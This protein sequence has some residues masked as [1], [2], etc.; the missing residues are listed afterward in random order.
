MPR[1]ASRTG[2][3]SAGGCRSYGFL[4]GS[5]THHLFLAVLSLTQPYSPVVFFGPF[6]LSR[7][8]GILKV[9]PWPGI[10]EPLSFGCQ[11]ERELRPSGTYW[12][13]RSESG[14]SFAQDISRLFPSSNWC[15]FG[16]LDFPVLSIFSKGHL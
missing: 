7:I 10:K 2:R 9:K 3:N 13:L 11:I 1:G 16:S 6:E 4:L 15:L 5:F 8:C 14:L 12:E